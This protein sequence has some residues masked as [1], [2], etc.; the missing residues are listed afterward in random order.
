VT[1]WLSLG[2][3]PAILFTP[4][5]QRLKAVNLPGDERPLRGSAGP[6]SGDA[7]WTDWSEFSNIPLQV[8]AIGLTQ[9]RGWRDPLAPRRRTLRVKF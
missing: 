8:G 6:E 7:G 4:F 1:E 3:G 5:S 9:K 2:A